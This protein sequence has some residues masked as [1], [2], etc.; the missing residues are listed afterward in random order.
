M[1]DRKIITIELDMKEPFFLW[2]RIARRHRQ[3]VSC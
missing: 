2:T 1:S 3:E